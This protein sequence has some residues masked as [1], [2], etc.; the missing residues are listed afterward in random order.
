V[1]LRREWDDHRM[2]PLTAAIWGGG[3]AAQICH[4]VILLMID[5]L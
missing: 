4:G 3:A 1:A 5:Y 2:S